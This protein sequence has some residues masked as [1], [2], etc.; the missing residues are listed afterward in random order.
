[1]MLCYIQDSP[2]GP[3]FSC[4]FH[5]AEEDILIREYPLLYI[6]K[7]HRFF[8]DWTTLSTPKPIER[9]WKNSWLKEHIF[10]IKGT[11]LKIKTHS[12][13]KLFDIPEMIRAMIF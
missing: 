8:V 2:N 13:L 1:M 12:D 4:Y 11:S 9:S 3:W 6:R 5:I 7:R 10:N